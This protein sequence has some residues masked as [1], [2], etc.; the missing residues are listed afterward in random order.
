MGIHKR[1]KEGSILGTELH[2]PTHFSFLCSAFDRFLE[3]YQIFL[4]L[5]P[6]NPEDSYNQ[7][8]STDYLDGNGFIN[9]DFSL[10]VDFLIS[11][12]PELKVTID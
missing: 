3:L 6:S 7:R 10:P 12:M 4:A 9:P 2:T 8:G 1:R 5:P 11:H